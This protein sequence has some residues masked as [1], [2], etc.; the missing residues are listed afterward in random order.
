MP[1]PSS[2]AKT[3]C[4][5]ENV[6]TH[7]PRSG[8]MTGA[9]PLMAPM[10]AMTDAR[11][12]P[13]QRSVAMLRAST[14]PPDAPSPWMSRKA[15]NIVILVENIQSA[16]DIANNTSVAMSGT[17][18]PYLS[19]SGPMMSWPMAR[20]SMLVVRPSCT[21]EVDALN[22]SVID[23]SA[24]RYMSVTNGANAVRPMGTVGRLAKKKAQIQKAW[25]YAFRHTAMQSLEK[26]SFD[27]KQK[28]RQTWLCCSRWIMYAG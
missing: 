13:E 8:D 11:A 16:E 22:D 25:I 17:F 7:P 24:G 5:V 12:L 9:M 3:A 4:H 26:N 28:C 15:T 6:S 21:C 1:I 10:M 14:T 18:R 19:L 23:G 27:C 20:P 2:M